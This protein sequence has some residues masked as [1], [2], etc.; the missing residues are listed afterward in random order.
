MS[1]KDI[2][3]SDDIASILSEISAGIYS[4]IN[5][6]EN[7]CF[8]GI[9]TRGIILAQRLLKEISKHGKSDI[10][11]GT[12]DITLYRDD[13]R[14]KNNWPVLEGSDIEFEVDDKNII[15]VDDV[16]YTGRTARAAIEAIM[17]YGRPA[18][19]KLAALIDRGDR[20]LPIHP[21]YCGLKINT[22]SGQ[23]VEVYLQETDGKEGVI[24]TS[25]K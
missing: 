13:F 6:L 20:E 19:I 7:V 8:V 21:D 15:I 22:D 18:S 3:N 11:L 12:I 24:I 25:R 9:R 23:R 17:D 4:D 10:P 2:I 5:N 16:I 1:S 14:T